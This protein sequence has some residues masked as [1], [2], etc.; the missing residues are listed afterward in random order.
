MC[1]LIPLLAFLAWYITT[2]ILSWY[3]LRKFQGPFLASFSC[4]SSSAPTRARERFALAYRAKPTD[5]RRPGYLETHVHCST[6]LFTREWY[7]AVRLHPDNPSMFGS[8]DTVW[9]GDTKAKTVAGYS[10]REAPGLEKDIDS[11]V[12]ALKRYIRAKYLYSNSPGPE[13]K[14]KKKKEGGKGKLLDFAPAAQNFALDVISKIAFGKEFGFL[15][16][17]RY[18]CGWILASRWIF[19]RT[20][21]KVTDEKGPGRIMALAKKAVDERFE[22]GGGLKDLPDMLG[23]FL[24]HGIT[25]Y[26][27]QAEG[28]LQITADTTTN[29][30]RTTMLYRYRYNAKSLPEVTTRNRRGYQVRQGMF[31]LITTAEAKALTYLQAV[32]Q[33]GLRIHPPT[34]ISAS[35]RV[36][37]AG[38]TL[39]DGRF[40]PSGTEI[41]QNSW[42]MLPNKTI[43]GQDADVFRPERWLDEEEDE[44]KKAEMERVVGLMF[45][46]G[47][48]MCAGKSIALMKLGKLFFELLREFDFQVVDPTR[49]WEMRQFLIFLF[50]GM[51]LM[52]V[53]EREKT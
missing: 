23:S 1:H 31:T 41:A 42:T 43:F 37:P 26:Q 46:H 6:D 4:S 29:V 5:N 10:G 40:L 17:D 51:M 14:K 27:C 2:A 38:D 11:V 21:P 34:L 47:R 3:P 36:P 18:R 33:E 30:I 19:E 50:R 49:P 52:R 35:K 15:E 12:L 22:G 9:H 24:R 28:V 45:G 53:T 25:R 32:I 8:R 48:W 39:P 20:R 16:A 44:K 7:D 13:K